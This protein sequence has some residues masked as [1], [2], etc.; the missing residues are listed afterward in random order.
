MESM[1]AVVHTR[2]GTPDV[3]RVVELPRPEPG[4]GEVLVRLRA[5]SLNGSDWE[6]LTGR[7]L[8]A[9]LAGVFR[10][11]RHILGSDIAGQVEAVGA[12][13]TGFAPGDDVFADILSRKG[14]FAEWVCVP[15]A[16]LVRMPEGLSYEQAAALPQAGAIALQGIRE[17][18]QVRAGQRVLVNGAG[19]GAGMY[20]VQL[21]VLDGAEV[22]GVD[23]AE[24]L[25]FVRSM[26]AAHVIDS[27][28]Q[29]WTRG[30]ERYDLVLDLAAYRSVFAYRRALRP[31]GRY[32]C[33]GGA[34]STLL[35]VAVLGPVLGRRAGQR[36]GVLAVRL[37]A[38]HVAELAGLCRAGTVRT[39]IDRR[40]R[41]E[42]VPDALRYVGQRRARGK[43]VVIL[44]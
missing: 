36:L 33:A 32:L 40:F 14:G 3:L 35:P 4:P 39:A 13:V 10:P 5:V 6:T 20:A 37:G 31:G 38:R 12:G 44:D 9:R 7:P 30:G 1:R 24:K 16:D 41:L 43:V 34:V 19:G 17:V 29:D 26:G 27:E 25:D 15:E 11:R 2:Y 22:T 28:A 21:A 18:G 42:E 23:N 8:Y